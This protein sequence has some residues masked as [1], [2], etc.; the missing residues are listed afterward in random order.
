[1]SCKV[2][3]NCSEQ[4]NAASVQYLALNVK[5]IA[6]KD[7]GNRNNYGFVFVVKNTMIDT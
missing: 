1:M 7:S 2:L 4:E 5:A 3:N 6:A